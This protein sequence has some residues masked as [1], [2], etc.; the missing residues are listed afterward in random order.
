M[1]IVDLETVKTFLQI[2]DSTYDALIQALIPQVEAHFE[3]IRGIPFD[4]D[5]N[6]V[7]EYPDNAELIAAQMV[8]YL[9]QTT[10]LNSGSYNDKS[11]ESIGSYS[12]SKKTGVEMTMGYPTS[13]IGRIERYHNPKT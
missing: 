9:I 2:S 12:Y 13:I 10:P 4:E 1:A 7:V 5:S 11:S 8:G 6:E 3:E